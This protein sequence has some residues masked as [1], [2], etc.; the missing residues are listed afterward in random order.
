VDISEDAIIS[1]DAAQRISLFNQGAE[2]IFGYPRWE[3]LG[4]PLEILIPRRFARAHHSHV[5][6]FAS[7]PDILR[8]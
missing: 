1:V 7:S 8:P 5:A 4:Q 6:S 2:K 3:V